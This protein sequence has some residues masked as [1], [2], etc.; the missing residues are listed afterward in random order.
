MILSESYRNALIAAIMLHFLIAIM[1]L[2]ESS[3]SER[4][5]LTA[6]TQT[7]PSA[8][9]SMA[10]ESQQ[11]AIQAVSMDS[12]EVMKTVNRLKD[13][14]AHERQAEEN[15]QRA[16]TQQ[17]NA[18]RKQRVDEQQRLEKL[19]NETA[20]L[21]IAHKK[22]M[23]DEQNHL[24]Q[25]AKQKVEEEQHLAD[26]KK[27]RLQIQKEQQQ[28]ADKLAVLKKTKADELARAAQ[29]EQVSQA[30]AAD[31]LIKKQQENQAKAADELAKKKQESQA[32]AADDLAE[33]Q[34]AAAI[35]ASVD[36]QKNA[37]MAGE[38]D[39]Y[40]AL[41]I[42]SISR[43]WILPENADSTKSSQFR[44]RLAPN[45]LVLEVTLTRSSGD[46]I[47]DR[48]AQSAI[49]KASPL[50]VPSNPDAFNLFREISLTVRPENA[51]G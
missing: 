7:V 43:Q 20:K 15:R 51:R 25:L 17:A 35:Q 18:A 9:Q 2:W 1:L 40:K 6:A 4:P 26:M 27:Q 8:P 24:K 49:Y 16:L 48:S 31:E 41:I 23:A 5:V 36:A 19:K 46:A 33:K 50:P 44:I 29:K 14:R 47:L 34:Q 39:K 3:S 42:G 37:Q 28:E 21:A 38:V 32:K 22:Q 12:Q 10:I 30:K 45:G 13:E 11:Q